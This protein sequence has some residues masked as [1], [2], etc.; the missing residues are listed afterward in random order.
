MSGQILDGRYRV[1][2]PLG[3]G[4]FGQ[5]YLA[6]DT[7]RPGQP[8]CVVK[9]LQL[10]DPDPQI[11]Q[12]ARR[13]FKT[14]AET[15]ETLGEHPQIPRLLAYFEEKDELYIVQEFI[16]GH[17]LSDELLPDRRLLS[18]QAFGLVS[19][20]L[21]VLEFV[22][23]HNV[24]H[25]DIKPSNIIRRHQDNKLV[26]IDFGAVKQVTAG[27]I[28]GRGSR[29]VTI[30][31]PGYMPTEQI[32]GF[33]HLSSDVYAVGAI[34]LQA[35]TGL[36][37]DRLPR[38]RDT[39]EIMWRQK[40]QVSEDL[41]EVLDGMVSRDRRQRYQSATEA[42][43]AVS[44]WQNN[45]GA[46]VVCSPSSSPNPPSTPK[47]TKVWIYTIA[48]TIG[49]GILI[50]SAIAFVPAMIEGLGSKEQPERV[51]E[52]DRLAID[53][54]KDHAS[55]ARTQFENAQR[56]SELYRERKRMEEAIGQLQMIPGSSRLYSEAHSLLTAYQGQLRSMNGR[57]DKEKYAQQLLDEAEA[58]A[59]EAKS[60]YAAAKNIS[61]LEGAGAKLIQAIAKLKQIP[62]DS[63]AHKVKHNKVAQYNRELDSINGEIE[64]RRSPGPPSN[65]DL[66]PCTLT[67]WG[68]CRE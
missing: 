18:A 51:E 33:P 40:A 57:L 11:M 64:K 49:L 37:P 48:A 44:S 19:E 42:L 46:T 58:I 1:T 10:A 55:S 68:N 20:I 60:D 12:T 3:S 43:Q 28:N 23:G 38:D 67:L 30:G 14:E 50:V 63:L 26:L 29:T 8:K 54:A 65:Q 31:T 35:L 59:G 25:R 66:P 7:R 34:G 5:T 22:H 13:L 21:E 16:Y 61:Q 47:Q 62:A 24:V 39:D 53:K 36:E 41:A 6:E 17:P 4:S 27:G 56:I 52:N 45:L 15:L 2:A 32:E 9:Q